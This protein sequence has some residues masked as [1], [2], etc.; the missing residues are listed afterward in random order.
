MIFVCPMMAITG[1]AKWC[2]GKNTAMRDTLCPC[3]FGPLIGWHQ[4]DMSYYWHNSGTGSSG[5]AL[6]TQPTDYRK[7]I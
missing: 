7:Q 5:A 6:K 1:A 3:V 4:S 2:L